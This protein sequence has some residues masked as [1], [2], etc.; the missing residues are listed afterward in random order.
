MSA[1]A[2]AGQTQPQVVNNPF[3]SS[4]PPPATQSSGVNEVYGMGADER[5]PQANVVYPTISNNVF[6][7]DNIA[8]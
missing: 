1:S 5:D 4:N 3:A 2:N 8:P 6:D 7:D